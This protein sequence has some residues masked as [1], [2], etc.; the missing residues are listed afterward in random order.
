MLSLSPI[1]DTVDFVFLA[2]IGR[3]RD[4]L[5]R[6]KLA[7]ITNDIIRH[8]ADYAAAG[9]ATSFY[10]LRSHTLVGGIVTKD[11]L[12]SVYDN[13]MV[14]QESRGRV[15]YDK[16]MALANQRRCPLCAQGTVKTLDHYLP[17]THFPGLAVCPSNLLPACSDCN[18]LKLAAAPT[19][20]SKQTLNPYYDKV[21]GVTWLQAKFKNRTPVVVEFYV[22]KPN[23]WSKMTAMR[24]RHHF[25]V[26]NLAQVYSCAAAVELEDIKE[27]L[28]NLLNKGG[29][30]DV[31][32]H[33]RDQAASRTVARKNSCGAALYRALAAS[34]WFCRHGCRG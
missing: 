29:A 19:C 33:L 13:Q 31:K 10:K 15:F 3:I 20:A 26:F 12:I 2:C 1:I 7:S 32:K 17:K 24:V 30:S 25:K 5:L 18:K 11:E 27:Y 16:I 23:E 22:K 9:R 34:S 6:N 28:T 21:D 8:D 4:D 14:P